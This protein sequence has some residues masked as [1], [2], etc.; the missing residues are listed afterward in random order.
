MKP[1]YN[2]MIREM[3]TMDM[4]SVHALV[5]ELAEYEQGLEHV[6]TTPESYL[7]DFDQ[8]LFKGFLAQREGDILGIAI[9]YTT[10]STWRG[11]MLYLEDIVVK[12]SERRSGIGELLFKAFLEKAKTDKV[13]LVKWL[14]LKWNEPA[15]NFYKK[16][17]TVFDD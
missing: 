3:D 1:T 2:I 11:R 14:V 7:R 13:A 8:G 6:T 5:R 9:S 17:P 10:F 4:D 16:Y 15:I 12:E